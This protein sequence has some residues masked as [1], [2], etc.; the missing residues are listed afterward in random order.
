MLRGK[1]NGVESL[2]RLLQL[3]GS[4]Q[5]TISLLNLDSVNAIEMS[6]HKWC[7]NHKQDNRYQRKIKHCPDRPRKPSCLDEYHTAQR[8]RRAASALWGA[9]WLDRFVGLRLNEIGNPKL[10]TGIRWK[11]A[12]DLVIENKS[13]DTQIGGGD[14]EFDDCRL[15][16]VLHW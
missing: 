1:R 6:D 13:T 15:F 12:V 4:H 14:G 9:S 2:S 7:E 5:L 16:L 8:L 11:A 10:D 3:A